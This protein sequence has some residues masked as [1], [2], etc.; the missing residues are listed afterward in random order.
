MGNDDATHLAAGIAY[1]SMFSIFPLLLATLA[2][3]GSVL[4][5]GSLQVD[6]TKFVTDNLPGSGDI[7]EQ[8][9]DQV[10]RFRGVVGCGGLCGPGLVGQHGIRGRSQVG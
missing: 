8:N 5:F 10:I 6:F 3:S 4:A 7:V 9:L 1:Y 2:V